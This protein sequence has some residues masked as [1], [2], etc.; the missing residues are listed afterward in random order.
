MARRFVRTGTSV[1][2]GAGFGLLLVLS[3]LQA[4]AAGP[5]SGSAAALGAA[6][7]RDSE[8]RIF[9][10][11]DLFATPIGKAFFD[12]SYKVLARVP[13][14]CRVALAQGTGW[15]PASHVLLPDAG[16]ND[17]FL[18]VHSRRVFYGALCG[19]LAG[20]T[21]GLVAGWTAARSIFDVYLSL[22]GRVQGNRGVSATTLQV[23]AC[24]ALLGLAL[25]P[26]GAAFGAWS[27]GEQERPGGSLARAWLMSDVGWLCFTAVGVGVDALVSMYAFDGAYVPVFTPIGSVLGMSLGSAWA[28]ES[29]QPRD[30]PPGFLAV[31]VMPP[32]VGFC[33]AGR[34]PARDPLRVNARLLSLR[35]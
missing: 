33:P 22:F 34:D 6:R 23:S 10:R 26:G 21:A 24:T 13:G 17:Y 27:A 20:S 9:P 5:D 11:P 14:W 18:G 1:I 31:R 7:V 4:A 12:S 2:A 19:S 30:G 29:S 35:F 25:A 8:T 28:Y 16:H 32:S 15:I 3:G